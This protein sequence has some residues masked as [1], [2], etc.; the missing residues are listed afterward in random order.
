MLETATIKLRQNK[1]VEAQAL[2][3]KAGIMLEVYFSD[4]T[5]Y[6]PFSGSKHPLMQTFLI[7]QHEWAQKTKNYERE[8]KMLND[9]MTAAKA[10][11]RTPEQM[12]KSSGLI[13]P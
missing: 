5:V 1:E 11:N 10:A 4:V 6:G 12:E 8:I 3:Q 9:F 13:L 7:A 2:L